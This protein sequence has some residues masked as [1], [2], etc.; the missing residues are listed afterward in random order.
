MEGLWLSIDGELNF[1]FIFKVSRSL[2]RRNV[3]RFFR[4]SYDTSCWLLESASPPRKLTNCWKALKTLKEWSTTKVSP[5][6]RLVFKCVFFQLSS[7]KSWLVRSQRI[8]FVKSTRMVFSK[9][10]WLS[11]AINYISPKFIR[12]FFWI[13]SNCYKVLLSFEQFKR[14]CLLFPH[15]PPY[16]GED[17]V[18]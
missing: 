14:S 13:S 4:L 15:P 11:T 16:S 10:L 2:T 8:K 12:T 5:K 1:S 18:L 6:R 7:R 9:A 3:E 17:L